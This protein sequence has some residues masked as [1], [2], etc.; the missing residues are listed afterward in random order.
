MA[1]RLYSRQLSKHRGIQRYVFFLRAWFLHRVQG[2]RMAKYLNSRQRTVLFW[3]CFS[4]TL[5]QHTPDS[6]WCHYQIMLGHRLKVGVIG[7]FFHAS[8][9]DLLSDSLLGVLITEPRI[10]RSWQAEQIFRNSEVKKY[11]CGFRS[12]KGKS[13]QAVLRLCHKRVEKRP[14]RSGF[15]ICSRKKS[16]ALPQPLGMTK[17]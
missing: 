17:A 8:I 10:P 11:F 5:Y 3:H 15:K 7:L 14:S 16:L 9:E 2:L 6:P 12:Q 1:L 4:L 13:L